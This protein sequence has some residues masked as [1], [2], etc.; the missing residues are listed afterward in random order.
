MVSVEILSFLSQKSNENYILQWKICGSLSENPIFSKSYNLI[1][2]KKYKVKKDEW[3]V[4]ELLFL[5][6]NKWGLNLLQNEF[7]NLQEKLRK[8]FTLQS[9]KF[10]NDKI[11]PNINFD[12]LPSAKNFF[13][14]YNCRLYHSKTALGKED[15]LIILLSAWDRSRD[16]TVKRNLSKDM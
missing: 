4:A 5:S 8:M 7:S 16:L 6:L 3:W 2:L 11:D 9:C 1:L 10:L 12:K 15:T 14:G 13:G